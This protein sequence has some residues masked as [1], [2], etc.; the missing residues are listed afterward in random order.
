M[1]SGKPKFGK[2]EKRLVNQGTE[3]VPNITRDEIRNAPEK[4]KMNKAPGDDGIGIEPV[5]LGGDKVLKKIKKLFNLCVHQRATPTRWHN[6]T[7]ILLHK[8]GDPR[9]IENFRLIILLNLSYNLFTRI[10]KKRLERKLY[11]H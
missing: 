9:N 2:T 7:T 8:K 10:I 6:A 5:T 1:I 4:M 3:E 11:F